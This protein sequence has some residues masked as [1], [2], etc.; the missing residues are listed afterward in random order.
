MLKRVIELKENEIHPE[1]AGMIKE[2][3]GQ[4]SLDEVEHHCKEIAGF[5]IWTK[6]VIRRRLFCGQVAILPEEPKEWKRRIEFRV[7]RQK[8][9]FDSRKYYKLWLPDKN[10]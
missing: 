5:Y 1:I 9:I 3:L 6:Q 4:Y 7:A 10:L 2:I 8:E